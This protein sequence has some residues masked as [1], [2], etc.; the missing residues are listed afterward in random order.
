MIKV[1]GNEVHI[2][3]VDTAL[4]RFLKEIDEDAV[5]KAEVAT[6]MQQLFITLLREFGES[7]TADMIQIALQDAI[8]A[9]KT[10][11]VRTERHDKDNP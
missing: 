10:V 3:I 2:G 5:V 4:T 7:V 11:N 9:Y 8:K 1:L 6:D